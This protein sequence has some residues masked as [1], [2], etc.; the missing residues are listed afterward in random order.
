MSFQSNNTQTN[1]SRILM[2]LFCILFSSENT[3][4]FP[5]SIYTLL[6]VISNKNWFLFN[7]QK[8]SE[9]NSDIFLFLNILSTVKIFFFVLTSLFAWTILS[10]FSIFLV[11]NEKWDHY[12]CVWTISFIL[13]DFHF[14]VTLLCFLCV[15]NKFACKTI[16]SNCA[17]TGSR[18]TICSAPRTGSRF[19]QKCRI[20]SGIDLKG[21]LNWPRTY[22]PVSFCC[23]IRMCIKPLALL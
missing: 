5:C 20:I 15:W 14:L 2:C 23:C 3:H 1:I 11:S 19:K 16:Y 8:K 6:S 12:D 10:P 7:K 18:R 17:M 4:P 22:S 21:L 9:E 13:F